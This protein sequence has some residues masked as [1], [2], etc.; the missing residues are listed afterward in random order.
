[1]DFFTVPRVTFQVLYVFFIT[2]HARWTV[3]RL[4]ITPYPGPVRLSVTTI[5]HPHP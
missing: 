1:M 4:G 2:L 3:L 5:C